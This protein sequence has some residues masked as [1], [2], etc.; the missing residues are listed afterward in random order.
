ME[1]IE[2]TWEGI[3]AAIVATGILSGAVSTA[4]SGGIELYRG[5]DK[6]RSERQFIA[7]FSAVALEEFALRCANLAEEILAGHE[8]Y[9]QINADK[10]PPPPVYPADCDWRL[11]D[12]QDTEDLMSFLNAIKMMQ[13]DASYARIFEDNPWALQ[14]NCIKLGR[15]ARGLANGLRAKYDL[16]AKDYLASLFERLEVLLPAD[17]T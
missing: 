10:L 16:P 1:V 9:G 6:R 8:T 2:W 13:A 7:L 15:R 17:K 4:I 5:R 3:G 11:M 14:T 12:L